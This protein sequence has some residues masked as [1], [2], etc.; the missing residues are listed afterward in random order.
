MIVGK[1][2]RQQFHRQPGDL[3]DLREVIDGFSEEARTRG[4]AS[5]ALARFA[6]IAKRFSYVQEHS[7]FWDV[8]KGR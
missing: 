4:F 3:G 8:P 6:F 7:Q 5:L 1:L 2:N